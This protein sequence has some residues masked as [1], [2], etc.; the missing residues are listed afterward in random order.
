MK[1][2][3]SSGINY[4]I[5]WACVFGLIELFLYLL[6]KFNPGS[7]FS[8]Q[9]YDEAFKK[10]KLPTYSYGWTSSEPMPR[11]GDVETA[12]RCAAAF[13]DSFTYAEELEAKDAWS[14]QASRLLNCK[15]ENYGVGGFGTDQAYLLY[16]EKKPKAPI[17][18]VG[19]YPEMLKRNLAASWIFY[20]GTPDQSLKP[21]FYLNKGHLEQHPLPQDSSVAEIKNYHSHDYFYQPYKLAF[22]Y[23]IETAKSLIKNGIN[24]FTVGKYSGLANIPQ[25]IELQD[26]IMARMREDI[27][28]NGSKIAVLFYPT[29]AEAESG[30]FKYT[31]YINHYRALH[32]NDCVI[33]V[34]RALNQAFKEKNISLNA[35]SGHYS[36]QA[37]LVIAHEVIRQL[38]SCQYLQ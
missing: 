34:G 21:F 6:F 11:P 4:I 25:A 28:E 16:R 17:V 3:G 5:A 7:I 35:G 26:A 32:P 31:E 10:A 15:I 2:L 29:V 12:S 33:E 27:L 22:P 18:I 1:K 9:Y 37:N 23:T 24:R 19:L 36:K 13:G 14:N 30:R 38:R 8:W 20:G